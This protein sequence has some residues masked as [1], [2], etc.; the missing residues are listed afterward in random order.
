MIIQDFLSC[1]HEWSS[2]P[3]LPPLPPSLH[4][5]PFGDPMIKRKD[6]RRVK[7]RN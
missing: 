4:D 5:L 3:E 2:G 1:D 7:R 6:L